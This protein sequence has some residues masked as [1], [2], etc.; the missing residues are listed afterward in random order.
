MVTGERRSRS[1]GRVEGGLL[2]D[3]EGQLRMVGEVP[4]A[5]PAGVAEGAMFIELPRSSL[6][7]KKTDVK[8]GIYSD[9]KL[10]RTVK[11][12]FVGPVQR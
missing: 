1:V 4:T 8:V 9:G 6:K 3:G 12:G 10:V 2:L 5:A 11:T 7:A